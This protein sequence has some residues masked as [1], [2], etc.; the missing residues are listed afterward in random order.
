MVPRFCLILI[1]FTSVSPHCEEICSRVAIINFQEVLVD[2]GNHQKGE[3][4]RHYLEK[5]ELAKYYLDTYQ[6]G[7]KIKSYSTVMGSLGLSF[8]IAGVATGRDNLQLSLLAGGLTV[9]VANILVSKTLEYANEDNLFRAIDEYNK[10][11]SPKIHLL[12][13]RQGLGNSSRSS[14]FVVQR[15]WFF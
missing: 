5:D 8:L 6:E 9:I 12:S 3:G 7:T 2:T 1:L 15:S 4:L 14:S 10:R 13:Q 11:N